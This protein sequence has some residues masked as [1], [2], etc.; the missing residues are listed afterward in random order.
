[1]AVRKQA[2]P[3]VERRK[4]SDLT[5]DPSNANVGTERGLSMLDDSLSVSGL[6]RSI[7]TDKHGVII[8]GNKTTERA[9]DR[10]FENAVIVHTRGDE[11]VVVQ[12]DDLDLA[13]NDPNNPARRMAYYDN[14][15][16]Q[17][18]LQW[19][20]EQL[21]ADVNAGFDF[22]HL[23]S[24]GEL[25]ALLAGLNGEPGAGGD[26]NA[27]MNHAEELRDKYQVERGQLWNIGQ[28]RLLCGDSYSMDDVDRLTEGYVVDMLHTDP[29]YGINIVQ[30]HKGDRSAAIGGSK[31]FGSTAS[32]GRKG[33]SAVAER[34][35]GKVGGG[36]G[37]P[38]R[39]SRHDVGRGNPA[40]IIQSNVYPVIEGD[41]HPF[42][43]TVFLNLAPI[44]I[45]WGA[46]YYA[47]QLPISSC[48]ICWDKREDITRNNFADCELAWT[49]LDKPARLFH[50]L[51]NGLH[52]GS[53]WGQARI[54]PT[55]KPVALFAEIG[56]MYCR[57]GIWLDLFAG[58]GAQIE[59]AE[60][61]GATCLALEYEP[62]YVACVL[63]RM[64]GMGLTPELQA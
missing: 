27:L 16:A 4:I 29:P 2:E 53:Q 17:M 55:E 35:S 11:L 1:M 15:V 60:Q 26:A 30:P 32:T 38:V 52:K 19:S 43:P 14:R 46:N 63:E 18:D 42:D 49:N 44:V 51:W 12:R 33:K 5:P 22:E 56:N 6:G 59:A 3:S 7:V 62:L 45:L 34:D 58:S 8:A 28:H 23:F 36:T 64:S 20:P 61:N 41:D 31:P 48:W 25:D 40:N 24:A 10:G 13:D 57:D 47:D 37:A 54:H 21:L 39:Q 50:H 9:I